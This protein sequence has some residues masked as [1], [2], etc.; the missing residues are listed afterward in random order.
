MAEIRWRGDNKKSRSVDIAAD[1]QDV[2]GGKEE[3]KEK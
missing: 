3:E 2:Y 1:E